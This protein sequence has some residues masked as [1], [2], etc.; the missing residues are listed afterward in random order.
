[1]KG[2]FLK[3]YVVF[4][5]L[6]LFPML[7]AMATAQSLLLGGTQ[8]G[9]Q[10]SYS[11]LGGILPV[12]GGALGNGWFV[13]TFASY[14]TYQY[15]SGNPA[16]LVQTRAPGFNAGLGYAWK[17]AS[18]ALALSGSVGYQ[19]FSVTPR[20]LPNSASPKPRGN[21]A[22][23][24]PQVQ[25]RYNLSK[26]LYLSTIDSYSFGQEAYWS[27]F[28]G[29]YQPVWWIQVGPEGILQGGPN[30]RIRQL[31]AFASFQLGHGWGIGLEGGINY[32]AGLKNTGYGSFSFSKT[33]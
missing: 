28:R 12:E 23:F 25:A 32:S 22:T 18:Y 10:N 3:Q 11:Y 31:G 15:H 4:F 30:Y 29:G 33:F 7:P 14:L 26:K 21:V 24:T 16:E 27:R 6:I 20:D 13:T 8:W 17:G 19:Y 5:S 9:P 2:I 1:M